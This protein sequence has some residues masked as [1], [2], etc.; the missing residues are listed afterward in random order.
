M[1]KKETRNIDFRKTPRPLCTWSVRLWQIFMIR[2]GRKWM[3]E[4][5]WF[6]H[7]HRHRIAWLKSWSTTR[8]DDWAVSSHLALIS[9]WTFL[10]ETERWKQIYRQTDRQ[11]DRDKHVI[12]T[13]Q[14]WLTLSSKATVT[15]K[16]CI[17]P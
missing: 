13:N 8:D 7:W 3:T 17:M 4:N 6:A 9:L 12:T 1:N 5:P 10:P 11:T 15:S 16:R 14:L 2:N